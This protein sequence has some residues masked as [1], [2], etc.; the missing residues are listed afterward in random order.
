M[1]RIR[2]RPAL[3][4]PLPGLHPLLAR[5]YAARGVSGAE[6]VA[7]GLDQL[8]PFDGLGGAREAAALLHEALRDAR[9]ILVVGD[10]DADGATSTALA[11]LGLRRL[12]AAQVD[13]LVPNR[14]EYGYGLTPEIVAL[15]RSRDPQLIIT[16]DNGIASVAGVAAARAAGIDVLV[17]DHHLPGA[18]LPAANVL[19]DPNLPGDAFASKALAG[20]GVMFYVLLA[21]RAR[22]RSVDWFASKGLD[23]PNLAELLD[24]VALGTVADVAR[25]DRNNRILVANGLRR[26]RAGRCR[27][28]IVA[29][30]RVAKRDP[31]RLDARDLGFAIGPRL[32]AAGRMDDMTVGIECLLADDPARAAALAG[33]LDALN[34]ERREREQTMRDEAFGALAALGAAPPP[35]IV[36]FD[37]GW[38]QGLVGLVASRVRERSARPTI[39]FADAGGGE[40]KGSGR[41]VDGLHLRDALEAIATREPDLIARFGGHAAAAGLTIAAGALPRFA[42]AFEAEVARL[43]GDGPPDARL[44]SDGELGAHELDAASVRALREG[45]PWGQGFPEPRFDGAFVVRDRRVVGERHLKLTLEGPAGPIPAIRFGWDD[46]PLPE[47]GAPV[48]ALY[49]LDLDAWR[50][51]DAVQLL[52][53]ALVPADE[54]EVG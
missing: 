37:P 22:L 49:A 10:Y 20:V 42:A 32:N 44:A 7:H 29:L 17:T 23:E 19:V 6:E 33:S 51:G 14:F 46:A 15:A 36:L 25:L 41:S 50:G 34:R 30:A 9:R 47:P 53:D 38:H 3:G 16:V 52:L 21:L 18:T 45:G 2:R 31:A 5:L 13:Y 24:L 12:G 26:I 1:L 11:V 40:L 8:L 48:H 4:A 28:G 35:G 54:V 27:P 39:A 43:L